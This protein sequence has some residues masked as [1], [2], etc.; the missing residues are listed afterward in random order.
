MCNSI[1]KSYKNGEL[2]TLKKTSCNE[3][4]RKKDKDKK[5]IKNCIPISLLNVD[6]KLVFKV[7][8]ERHKKV[9]SSVISKNHIGLCQMK[10]D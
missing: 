2:S 4:Y 6:T 8:A 9:L 5:L 3:T 1:T 10:I 7:L